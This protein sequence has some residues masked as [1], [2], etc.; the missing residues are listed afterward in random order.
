[1][2]EIDLVDHVF[3]VTLEDGGQITNL[4]CKTAAIPGWTETGRGDFMFLTRESALQLAKII[5]DHFGATS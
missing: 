5:T 3:I 1:M 4:R 2:A